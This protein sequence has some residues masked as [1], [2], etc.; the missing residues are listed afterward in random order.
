MPEIPLPPESMRPLLVEVGFQ[1][2][3]RPHLRS[4]LNGIFDFAE[5]KPHWRL[6]PAAL[7]NYDSTAD[8]PPDGVISGVQPHNVEM[9]RSVS[10]P[11]VVLEPLGMTVGLPWVGPDF[12]AIGRMGADYLATRGFPS[13]VYFRH[14]DASLIDVSL[15]GE[16]FCEVT[17]KLEVVSRI[18]DV[19]ERTRR[20]GVWTLDDQAADLTDLLR[21]LPQPVGVL[22]SDDHQGWQALE[23]CK[24]HGI[25][26]PDEVAVLGI[27]NDE[28]VCNVCRPALSSIAV[29]HR[30]VGYE[31]AAIM[32]GLLTAG[33]ARDRTLIDDA[34]VI[35][36]KSTSHVASSDPDVAAAVSFIAENLVEPLTVERLAE[37]VFV[38]PRTLFRNLVMHFTLVSIWFTFAWYGR[39]VPTESDV[40]HPAVCE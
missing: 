7:I 10:R 15:I 33:K 31:S 19:G 13:L 34:E 20:K 5:T 36:R 24:R 3:E 26:V 35:T 16:G 32:D 25:A 22:C 23:A 21:S 38:S 17:E 2:T 8:S 12:R 4:V 27:G 29:N 11:C 39:S 14:R 18:F 6:V 9:F 40:V 30:R 1:P 37:A 28:F